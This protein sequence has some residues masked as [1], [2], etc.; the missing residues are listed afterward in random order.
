MIEDAN[1]TPEKKALMLVVG[2]KAE[3]ILGTK[4][5]NEKMEHLPTIESI[6]NSI[7]QEGKVFLQFEP[8]RKKA[9][10]DPYI[11]VRN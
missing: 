10:D 8:M 6:V 11:G 5:F 9:I 4:H 1:I 3:L 2:I 7:T